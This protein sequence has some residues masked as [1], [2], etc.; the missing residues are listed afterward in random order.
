MTDSERA[1][2]ISDAMSEWHHDFDGL[3]KGEQNRHTSFTDSIALT[4]CICWGAAWRML[5]HLRNFVP[6]EQ[7]M[8]FMGMV[9]ALKSP[10][11]DCTENCMDGPCDCSGEWIIRAWG[12]PSD[13][14]HPVAERVRPA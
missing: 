7:R 9:P 8:A 4:H 11:A 6:V 14:I 12:A 1:A 10:P 5:E 3:G 13:P 2:L